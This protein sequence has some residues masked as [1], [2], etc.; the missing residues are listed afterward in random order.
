MYTQ[1]PHCQT[2]F[3]IHAEQ[4]RAAGGQVRCCR[5]SEIF[6]AVEHLQDAP[7]ILPPGSSTGNSGLP[8]E[9]AAAEYQAS[10][11][12]PAV[13]AA[14]QDEISLAQLFETSGAGETPHATEWEPPFQFDP[15]TE[16]RAP[17]EDPDLLWEIPD[18]LQDDLLE[19]GQLQSPAAGRPSP[20]VARGKTHDLLQI[21]DTQA[22]GRPPPPFE[23]D[24]GLPELQPTEPAP[25]PFPAGRRSGW[26]TLFWTLAILLLLMTAL[27]Q[28]AWQGRDRL[29]RHYPQTRP[30]LEWFCQWAKCELSPR[31]Q[32]AL[33]KVVERSITLH[34]DIPN[35]LQIHLTFTNQAD[36]PQPCPRI[37]LNLYRSDEQLIAR[38]NFN[39][40]EYACPTTS[41][42]SLIRPGESVTVDLLAEDPGT[43]ATGFEFL[44]F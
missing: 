41:D 39:P 19:V 8:A 20:A 29:L 33:L 14:G 10:V 18:R 44:F 40:G 1:C 3:R 31:K 30:A 26:N 36:F 24:H 43:Q 28:L 16:R 32:P 22:E 5:C 42:H 12:Q 38:R 15:A 35:A 23:I 25:G 37:L 11:E 7:A 17:K 34:P 6:N 21:P 27:G 2:Q 4:L 9:P 13:S